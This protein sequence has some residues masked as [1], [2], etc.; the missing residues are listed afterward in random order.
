MKNEKLLTNQPEEPLYPYPVEKT[1]DEELLERSYLESP[2]IEEP[3]GKQI[4]IPQPEPEH[5]EDP[6]IPPVTDLP[7]E[8]TKPDEGV[9]PHMLPPVEKPP[10]N[11]P[12]EKEDK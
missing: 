3:T 11:T 9:E 8:A 6:L 2:P 12:N 5:T 1:A 4:Q 7:S 10:Y